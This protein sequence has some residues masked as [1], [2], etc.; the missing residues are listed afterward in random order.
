MIAE[1]S[2]K[3]LQQNVYKFWNLCI[4]HQ[5]KYVAAKWLVDMKRQ[6]VVD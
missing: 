3:M 5:R 2:D 4:Q 1:T 6:N